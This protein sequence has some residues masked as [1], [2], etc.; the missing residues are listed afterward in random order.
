MWGQRWLLQNNNHILTATSYRGHNYSVAIDLYNSFTALRANSCL[1]WIDRRISDSL[2]R[3]ILSPCQH[4]NGY[5][6]GRSQIWVHTDERTQDHSE[7][8]LK[9]CGSYAAWNDISK[10]TLNIPFSFCAKIYWSLCYQ[11]LKRSMSLPE[12]TASKSAVRFR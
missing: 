1:I 12:N 10:S 9:T 11:I 5:I 7:I 8:Y 2:V 4:D 3:I 6:D